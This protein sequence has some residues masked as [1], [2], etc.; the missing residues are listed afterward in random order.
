MVAVFH[1]HAGA[2]HWALQSGFVFLLLHSLRWQEPEHAGT[3]TARRLVALAWVIQSFVWMNSGTGKF[4]MPF[5]PGAVVLGIYCA[6]QLWSGQWNFFAVPAAALLVVLS[7]PGSA[8][9]DGARATPVGLL[10]VTASFL[11]FGFGTIAALTRHHWHKRTSELG[12]EP[13]Q[14]TNVNR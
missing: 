13:P 1:H 3:S 6:C 7:G 5:I 12:A 2:A 8:T 11:L 10:A 14:T 4:W 9:V